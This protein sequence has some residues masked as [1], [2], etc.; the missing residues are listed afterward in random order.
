MA[1]SL[2]SA[3]SAASATGA[4][5]LFDSFFGTMELSD[6]P[7][8]C[9]AGVRSL[10]FPARVRAGGRRLPNAG[11]TDAVLVPPFR[12]SPLLGRI[13]AD[14]RLQEVSIPPQVLRFEAQIGFVEHVS[15]D[16]AVGALSSAPPERDSEGQCEPLLLVSAQPS[17]FAVIHRSC[18]EVGSAPRVSLATLPVTRYSR[19]RGFGPI[20]SF[21]LAIVSGQTRD[22]PVPA[23]GASVHAEGLRPR[24]VPQ[25][26]A[27]TPRRVL[28][29][30]SLNDVGTPGRLISRLNSSPALSPVNAS[31][32][33]S[34]SKPH[35]SGSGWLA[36]P[37]PCDSFIH[38]SMPV[39]GA[40]KRPVLPSTH[41]SRPGRCS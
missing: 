31:A 9:V 5:A 32:P 29:S 1:S 30:A 11:S 4:V 33:T 20:P 39:T 14:N 23:H 25:G 41:L 36:G 13:V 24:R 6:F 18:S 38:Y 28:P 2:P 15:P 8:P 27:V 37:F 19:P 35:D 10:T 21:V 34:R 22:L 16:R 3:V 17:L 40:S 12:G 7:R 26:L